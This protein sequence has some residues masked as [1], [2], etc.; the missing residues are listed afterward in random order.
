MRSPKRRLTKKYLNTK[1][2]FSFHILFHLKI[3]ETFQ[4]SLNIK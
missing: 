2:P 1:I 4:L 3:K